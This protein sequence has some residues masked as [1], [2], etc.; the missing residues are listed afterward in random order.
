MSSH[1]AD[2]TFLLVGGFHASSDRI[3]KYINNHPEEQEGIVL[4]MLKDSFPSVFSALESASCTKFL[5]KDIQDHPDSYGYERARRL[6][7]SASGIKH[8]KKRIGVTYKKNSESPQ[9]CSRKKI[10]VLPK[11]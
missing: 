6:G 3:L 7:V 5:K 8:A 11:N 9:S 2:K 4:G 1:F 10:Y